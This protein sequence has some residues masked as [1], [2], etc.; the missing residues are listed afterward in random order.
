[1]LLQICRM[2]ASRGQWGRKTG[3]FG[4]FAVMGPDEFQMM[5]NNNCYTNLMGKKTFEYTLSV[6]DEIKPN[7]RISMR[8]FAAS[9]A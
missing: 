9:S 2:L 5:V 1:M 7:C 8:S 6:L 4:Y 3:K